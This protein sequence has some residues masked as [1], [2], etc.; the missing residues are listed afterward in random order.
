[1]KLYYID[2]RKVFPFIKPVEVWDEQGNVRYRLKNEASFGYHLHLLTPGE[3]YEE[4][5]LP[6]LLETDIHSEI[7]GIREM[8]GDY[9]VN[10]KGGILHPECDENWKITGYAW[11]PELHETA[12]ELVDEGRIP[13]VFSEDGRT[14]N[15]DVITEEEVREELSKG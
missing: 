9:I 1:M 13:I 5:D 2:Q 15:V 6:V 7:G 11:D 10:V 4:G 3:I 14:P 8:L 12:E